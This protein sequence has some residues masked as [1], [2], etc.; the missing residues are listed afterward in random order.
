META[1]HSG[2]SPFSCLVCNERF[3]Q[4]AGLNAHLQL[5]HNLAV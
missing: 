2:E 3:G 4:K 5:S 1:Q